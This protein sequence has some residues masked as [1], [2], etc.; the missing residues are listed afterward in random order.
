MARQ[1]AIASLAV[2]VVARV[3]KFIS[4]MKRA[5]K[6]IKRFAVG[7]AKFG[8]ALG[9]VA[10]GAMVVFTKRAFTML[11]ALAKFSSRLG[12][13]VGTLVGFE[14]AATLAGSSSERLRKGLTMM[15]KNVAEAAT[16]IGEAKE[17]LEDLGLD[18]KKLQAQ[19][20]E[21]TFVQILDAVSKIPNEIEQVGKMADI[22]GTRMVELLNLAN[23]GAE[24]IEK[25]TKEGKRLFG[26]FSDVELENLQQMNDS[27]SALGLAMRGLFSRIAVDS[28]PL[29]N[30]IVVLTTNAVVKIR[31]AAAH[32]VKD[33]LEFLVKAA[34]VGLDIFP[35]IHQLM[36]GLE[37]AALT[38]LDKLAKGV[39]EFVVG[40]IEMLKK[41]PLGLLFGEAV[42]F[43]SVGAG[44]FGDVFRDR[45]NEATNAFIGF[46][47][48][49]L[50]SERLKRAFDK[51]LA[52]LQ[53]RPP[54]AT[55]G[56][57]DAL[58]GGVFGGAARTGQFKQINLSRFALS[59]LSGLRGKVQTTR[60]P[61]ALRELQR[62]RTLLGRP[63]I[64]VAG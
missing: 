64:A 26:T 50:P 5:R 1:R 29:L 53:I 35:Q 14:H 11:D 22:F 47:A 59:A 55:R 16:G 28:A 10:V 3:S 23:L 45:L 51:I 44:A 58:S 42:D 18:A 46:A 7:V 2:S 61:E 8:A 40:A 63:S 15:A 31:S 38:T 36:L 6:A 19:G 39:S 49:I 20:V 43:A 9:A 32:S 41:L 24:G 27:I 17:A 60:D 54:G 12:I 57:G 62:I 13:T 21:K 37:L 33:F 4:R 56:G 25:L 34:G 48:R 52:D 30:K